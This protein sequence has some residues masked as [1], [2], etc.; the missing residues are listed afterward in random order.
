MSRDT[1]QQNNEEGTGMSDDDAPRED[2]GD[3][4]MEDSSADDSY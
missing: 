3:T 1:P 4:S 2:M